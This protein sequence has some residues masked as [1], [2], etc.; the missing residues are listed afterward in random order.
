MGGSGPTCIPLVLFNKILKMRKIK[1]IMVVGTGAI[2]NPTLVNQK[3]T[4]PSIS[5]IVE[6]EVGNVN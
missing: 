5:H 3:N 6:I 1:R 2:H 4:I